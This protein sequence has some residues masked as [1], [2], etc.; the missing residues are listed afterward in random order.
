LAT[1]FKAS[2][3]KILWQISLSEFEAHVWIKFETLVV[4]AETMQF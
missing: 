4:T 1:G 3:D 2:F